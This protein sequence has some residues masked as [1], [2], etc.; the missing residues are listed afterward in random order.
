[1]KTKS[2]WYTGSIRALLLRAPTGAVG[3]IVGGVVSPI[4]ANV[5]LHEVLDRWFEET[6]KPRLQGNACLVRFADDFVIAFAL[7]SDARR[8]HDVL[9]K[10]FGK[11]GLTLHPEK[12]Q[13]VPFHRPRSMEHGKER[14]Q[15]PRPGSF[16]L[17]GFCHYWARSRRGFWVIKR[18]TAPSRFTRALR[19]VDEWCRRHRH[20]SIKEQRDA[21]AKKLQGHCGYYGI[22]G[23]SQALIRFR[24]EL[25]RRWHRWL[26]RRS[27]RSRMDWET[28][29]KLLAR[30]PLPPAKCVHSEHFT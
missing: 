25:G 1:M 11:Y 20:R 23:N 22:T 10:R 28:F 26:N 13:L 5:Y 30:Y 17:L 7:E 6:V 29:N 15:T 3:N 19:R 16:E 24:H 2:R 27:Q 18:K 9:P 14:D 8:V 21:L 12:T 4:L